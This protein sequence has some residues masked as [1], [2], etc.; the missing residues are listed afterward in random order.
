M[1]KKWTTVALSAMLAGSLC[2]MIACEINKDPTQG[3]P[4]T[5]ETLA[6]VNLDINPS[7]ELIVD[8]NNNVVSVRG[9]N[10]D[11]LV[12]LYNE[13]GIE[14]ESV[15]TAVRKITDLAI[16]YGYIN[17]NNKVV[18]TIVTSGDDA[19][20]SEINDKVNASVTA[21]AENLGIDITVDGEAAYSL[22]RQ[23]NAFKAQYPDDETIQAL[24]VT[25]FRL[26]LSVSE[27]GD[28]SLNAAVHLDDA[29]LIAMLKEITPQLE[30]Y[31]TQA[32]MEVKTKALAV[33][34]QATELAGYSVYTTYYLQKIL[35]HPLTAYYGG[36]YQMYASAAKGFDVI[37]DVA[38][39]ATNI[40]N[41]PLSEE[42]VAA[43]VAALRLESTDAL[44]DANGNVTIASVEAYADVLFKNSPASA[45]LEAC[46]Q[47]L[48]E[49]LTAA[50][51][52][53]K[54]KAAEIMAEYQPQIEAAVA[55]AQAVFNTVENAFSALP[56][57]LQTIFLNGTKEFKDILTALNEGLEDGKIDVTELRAFADRLDAKAQEYL[58]KIQAD[59]SEEELAELEEK[60]MAVIER[61]T[62]E[63]ETFEKALDEAA[64]TAKA[65][66]EQLKAERLP[67]E[68]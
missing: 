65:Y 67:S 63:K 51:A 58:D 5:T 48:D 4:P 68:A 42:Q 18:D 33:Y 10:E 41:Y 49:A 46:K 2:A 40:R 15:D 47:A 14:G 50:E 25:T 53:L 20:A 55:A 6:Y 44:K 57:S 62:K 64:K 21:T 61:M 3:T 28:I 35:S 29:Q 38:E 12:L 9:E 59:L 13:T 54:E 8:K 24:S 26:A 45:E 56:E 27:T 60:R 32:Y 16:R 7:I 22:I 31:A 11:G 43:V 1:K 66:L 37:C 17:E 52:M 39:L 34:E 30:A 19:F 36:I 23:W